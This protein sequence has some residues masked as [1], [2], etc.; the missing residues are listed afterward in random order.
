MSDWIVLLAG[1]VIDELETMPLDIQASF[2]RIVAMI[3]AKGLLE[4]R[5]TGR[6]GIVQAIYFTASAKRA[7]VLRVFT[8][9]R[10]RRHLL[11]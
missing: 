1:I 10:K 7:I 11:K 6:D 9:K 2:Q 3:E 5:M 4:M 8:K